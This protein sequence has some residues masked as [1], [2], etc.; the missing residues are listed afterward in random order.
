[1]RRPRVVVK[2]LKE[3]VAALDAEGFER[4]ARRAASRAR[5][6]L[7]TTAR[8]VV[9]LHEAP[10]RPDLLGLDVEEHLADHGQ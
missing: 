10:E 3:A 6:R 2:F 1:M 7:F 9:V 5:S 8:P 4:R